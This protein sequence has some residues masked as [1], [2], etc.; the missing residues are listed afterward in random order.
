MSVTSTE[1]TP[2]GIVTDPVLPA[3]ENVQVVTPL[4]VVQPLASAVVGGMTK[5]KAAAATIAQ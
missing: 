2:A 5:A 1:V 4:V 3:P